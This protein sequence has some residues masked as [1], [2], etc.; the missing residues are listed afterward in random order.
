MGNPKPSRPSG[1]KQQNPLR[2]WL[3]QRRGDVIRGD[4]G[5]GAR[6]V[7]IGKN[8]IQ[9]GTLVV[10]LVPVLL[11]LFAVLAVAA[12]AAWLAFTDVKMPK[13]FNIAVAQ[14]GE[15]DQ[16]GKLYR[17]AVGSQL[18]ESVYQELG[19]QLAETMAQLPKT[20]EKP[21][22]H[23]WHDSLFPT[24]IRTPL[25][26]VNDTGEAEKLAERI[27]ASLVIYGKVVSDDYGSTFFPDFYAPYLAE[28]GEIIDAGVLGEEL[29]IDPESMVAVSGELKTRVKGLS[30]FTLGLLYDFQDKPEE[31]MAWFT[32][33]KEILQSS[34]AGRNP[35]GQEVMDY[36][37]GR[38]A[39]LARREPEA[40]Q[41]FAQ[42]LAVNPNYAR[43]YIARGNVYLGYAEQLAPDQRLDSDLLKQAMADYRKA[44]EVEAQSPGAFLQSKAHMGLSSAY[45]LQAG[46]YLAQG[47]YD[48]ANGSLDLA[49]EEASG[50]LML[51]EEEEREAGRTCHPCS[52][53]AFYDLGAA[54]HEKAYL[55][56]C[57][58]DDLME[59]LGYYE[60][61][62]NSY[63][64]CDDNAKKQI[65]VLRSEFLVELA[66]DQCATSGACISRC[67]KKLEEG[68]NVCQVDECANRCP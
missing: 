25:G 26:I 50:A 2:R 4:V 51:L 54:Y 64:Q 31:A 24:R 19:S 20:I 68:K 1:A 52:A 62:R 57:V 43:V 28:G 65:Q 56:S 5:E 67:L 7:V 48:E 45:R 30:C 16:D 3:S 58:Y 17:S 37:I 42:A 14:F 27:G 59:G 15:A 29:T 34:G 63:M 22:V 13:G 40:L 12:V 47:G 55:Y 33:A 61:A 10:P 36:F 6:G 60:D 18:S 39:V 11:I 35:S 53:L 32:Q 23:I 49:I 41:A 46:A 8:V 66:R 38:E 44:M 21:A 9:V